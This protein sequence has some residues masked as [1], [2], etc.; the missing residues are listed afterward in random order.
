VGRV[1][2]LTSSSDPVAL[3]LVGTPGTGSRWV[4]AL[5]GWRLLG[6]TN[7]VKLLDLAAKNTREEG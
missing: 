6:M 2:F 5:N 3:L 7:A 4:R 1:S